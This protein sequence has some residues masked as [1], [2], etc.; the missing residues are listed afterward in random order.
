MSCAAPPSPFQRGG[1]E[2]RPRLARRL[3]RMDLGTR[4]TSRPGRAR[5]R[6]PALAHSPGAGTRSTCCAGSAPLPAPANGAARSRRWSHEGPPLR[7]RGQG[8]LDLLEHR[9]EADAPRLEA[10]EGL[11]PEL[12]CGLGQRDHRRVVIPML[13][14]GDLDDLLRGATRIGREL[15]QRGRFARRRR[16]HER[17]MLV[18][19][20]MVA[21]HGLHGPIDARD[22]AP[23]HEPRLPRPPIG[24]NGAMISPRSSLDASHAPRSLPRRANLLH[25]RRASP[26]CDRTRVVRRR[27]GPCSARQLHCWCLDHRARHGVRGDPAHLYSATSDTVPEA[28]DVTATFAEEL[29]K[30]KLG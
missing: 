1:I 13:P 27:R 5:P 22:G 28:G 29:K 16:A 7:A 15:P 14:E 17:H 12:C 9:L 25:R 24:L 18:T 19:A 2:R 10:R 8:L 30:R 26:R 3:E 23:S 4:S 6:P 11:A 21:A 20:R